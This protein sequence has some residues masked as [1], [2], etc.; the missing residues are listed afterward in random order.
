MDDITYRD[1]GIDGTYLLRAWDVV[2]VRVG[3]LDMIDQVL[4]LCEVLGNCY[5]EDGNWARG[6]YLT[7]TWGRYSGGERNGSIAVCSRRTL[8]GISQKAMA[9]CCTFKANINGMLKDVS[10]LYA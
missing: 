2:G 4:Q 10:L 8:L 3:H 1:T 6:T 5:G 7:L 9:R